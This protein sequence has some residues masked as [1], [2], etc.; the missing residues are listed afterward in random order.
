M[1]VCRLCDPDHICEEAIEAEQ[2]VLVDEN[3]RFDVRIELVSLVVVDEYNVSD[4][5]S[6]GL[7]QAV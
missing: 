1:A 7:S 4:E 6:Q 3:R 2:R 5:S